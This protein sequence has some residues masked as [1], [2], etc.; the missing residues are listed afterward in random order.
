MTKR[1][2][3]SYTS[4]CVL[5]CALLCELLCVAVFC[6]GSVSGRASKNEAKLQEPA[7]LLCVVVYIAV[8]CF[9]S[10]ITGRASNDEAKLRELHDLMCVLLYALLYVFF[11]T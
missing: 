11:Y 9:G 6:C 4:C 8:C 2:Y 10:A 5:R 3:E 1:N 7:E